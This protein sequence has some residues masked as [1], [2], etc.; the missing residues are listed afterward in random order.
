MKFQ[1][2]IPYN[3]WFPNG[4][5]FVSL[6]IVS[7]LLPKQ[8]YTNVFLFNQKKSTLISYEHG[9]NIMTCYC[10]HFKGSRKYSITFVTV[11]IF[12]ESRVME[13]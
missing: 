9:N 7:F 1:L 6:L 8:Y 2:P 11:F 10:I 13:S 5:K 12:T 4:V 3:G